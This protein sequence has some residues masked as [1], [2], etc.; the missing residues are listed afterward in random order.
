MVKLSVILYITIAISVI[1]FLSRSP[2][3]NNSH[4]Q[5]TSSFQR[6]NHRRLKLRSNFTFTSQDHLEHPD[7]QLQFRHHHHDAVAFDPVVAEIERH[8]EDKEWERMYFEEHHQEIAGIAHHEEERENHAEGYEK[9]PEWEDFMDAEDYL[10]DEEKFNVTNRLLVLFPKIDVDPIDGYVTENELIE[11]NLQ[12]T[13][14]EVLHRTQREM[15]VH[16]KNRDGFVSFSEYDPPSW[17][18]SADNNTFGYEMG[19][20]RE[21]HFNASDVNGDGLL[22]ITEFK[23]FLH[24]A[25]T[26]NPKLHQW[27]CKEEIRERDTDKDGKVNFNEFFHGLFDLVRNY[28]EEGHGHNSTHHTDDSI[29]TPAAR[30]LFNELDKDGDGL[31]T[32]TEL[33]PIID[34]LHP[35]ERH[36]AKQQ[37]DYIISQADTNKDGRLSLA[38]MIENPYVF[39]STIFSDEDDYDYHDELR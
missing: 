24:P 13:E 12:Q 18:K 23:D 15:E 28:E 35:S 17:V 10:N 7:P 19:W 36:Y 11:W 37:A 6:N 33:L 21:E 27:L 38:E 34:K 4:H 20:W 30:K 1:F 16:D 39:Y 26:K 3:L 5:T 9:Q 32:E 14:R 25:D 29:E 2:N 31:L 22:N 8:R